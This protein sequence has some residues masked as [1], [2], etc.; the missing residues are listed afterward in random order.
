MPDTTRTSPPLSEVPAPASLPPELFDSAFRRSP[1]PACL[2]RLI[3]DRIVVVNDAFV[4]QTG[5]ARAALIGRAAQAVGLWADPGEWAR[6]R[7]QLQTERSVNEAALSLR[8]QAGEARRA[9]A[10]L[11]VI[12]AG[13]GAYVL[14]LFQDIT[15]RAR[16]EADL[17]RSE[18]R[19]ELVARA[20]TDAVYDWNVGTGMTSWNHGMRTLFGYPVDAEQAHNWWRAKVHPDDRART[21]ASVEAALAERDQFWQCEY[22]YL[23]ADGS[24][25]HVLD[26]GYILYDEAGQPARMVGAMIDITSR[27]ELAEAHAR[28]A[29]EERQRLARELH[30]S[31]T[32]SLYSLTLLAEAG[33][34]LAAAG[35]LERVAHYVGRLGET[36]QQALKEMRLLVYQLRPLAL[37]TVGL[38]GALQH[39]LDAV[40]KRGGVQARLEVHGVADLPPGVEADLFRVAQEALNNALKHAGASAVTVSLCAGDG[41]VGLEIADNGR[42]FDLAAADGGGLGL[43]SMRERLEKLGGTLVVASQP[44]DGTRI[45]ARVR[46]ETPA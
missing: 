41:V 44:G 32:Q 9:L 38:A 33:R 36:A 22:R 3:D 16:I 21:V 31:V 8:T 13:G 27:V 4:Q 23:R 1:I 39:R 34:R 40:E 2:I 20:T 10:S 37:E 19:F 30:D 12:E 6:L 43:T 26:R 29:L 42:G 17:R 28:A 24:Y 15:E 5:Y 45:L 46:T 35:D 25:A 14:V 18:E 11:E 7:G